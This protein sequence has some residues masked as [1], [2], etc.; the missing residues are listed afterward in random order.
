LEAIITSQDGERRVQRRARTLLIIYVIAALI[1]VVALL[2]GIKASQVK[3]MMQVGKSFQPPPESVSTARVEATRWQPVRSAVGSLVAVHGVT[4]GAELPGVIRQIGFESGTSVKKGALLVKLDTSTEQAQLEAA[5]ADAELA[6]VSL[7]R[8]RTLRSSESNTPADLDA[9]EARKKQADATVAGLRATIAKKT[10]RAP[11]DGRIAIRQVE[12]GQ[13]V[14]LGTQLASLQSVDPIYA[15]FSLPQQV[16]ADLK[17]GLKVRMR[18]DI[19]PRQVWEGTL[20]TINSEIDV[21]TRN[22]RVRATFPNPGGR[23]RPG[24]FVG[25][26][27]VSPTDKPTLVIPATAA[28]YA[29]YGDSVFVVEGKNEAGG[30]AA[31][32]GG[33]SAPMTAPAP[34]IVR[35]RF[36]RLGERRGDLIAVDAGLA[37]GETVVSGG[38]FKLKS[39]GEVVINNELAPKVELAPQPVDR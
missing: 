28:L 29:P 3:A 20:S 38:A 31:G 2:A 7:D 24:M 23:L 17:L 34:S 35:Q 33:Q 14:S 1:L 13:S 11:F 22:V 32:L 36:V 4:L 15:E 16:L 6:R 9:A 18:T 12:L 27:V 10:I 39:G 8:A 5:I 30:R 21:Q 19:F 26:D 37:A 25:V